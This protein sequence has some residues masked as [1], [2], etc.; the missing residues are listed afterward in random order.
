MENHIF[1]GR[2]IT[3]PSL[4]DFKPVKLWHRQLEKAPAPGDMPQD[5]HILFRDSFEYNGGKVYI[6]LTADDYFKLYINGNFVTQGPAPGFDFKYYYM[7]VDIT[8]HVRKGKNTVA[9]H[10]YYQGLV[11][12][13]WCSA[14]NRHGLIYDIF[15]DGVLKAKSSEKTKC[16]IHTAYHVIGKVGYDTQF[17]EMYDCR[18]AEIGFEQPEYDDSYWSDSAINEYADY[19]FIEQPTKPLDF[20]IIAPISVQKTDNGLMVDFGSQY[21]GY[22]IFNA[23]GKAG[24]TLKLLCGQELND[25]GNVRYKL[26]ANCTYEEEMVLSGRVDRFDQYDYMSF[27]YME[28]ILPEGCEISEIAFISRHYPFEAKRGCAYDDPKLKAVWELCVHSLKYGV[29]EVIQDC[30]EREKGQYLG[31]GSYTSTALA[32]LTD[33]TSMMEKMITNALDT[34]FIT[35]T[36]M[37]CSPCSFMQEIAEYVLMLPELLLAQIHI[38]GNT[39]FAAENF[40]R[41][42]AVLDAYRTEYEREDHLLYDL[43]KWCVVD[44]PQEARDSYDFD[45]TEGKVAVG[46]HNVINAYYIGAINSLNKIAKKLGRPIYRDT[47]ELVKAYRATFFC[48]EKNL[49]RDSPESGHCALP[50]NA[51][52]LAMGLCPNDETMNNIVDMIMSK[53]ATSSAFFMTFASMTGLKRLG[54][55]DLICEMIKNDS[56]WLNMIAEGHTTTI[57][58]WGKASKWNTSLFHLCY[59]FAVIFLSDWGME[60]LFI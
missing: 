18:S 49:F 33:D 4:K 40:D 13:V 16:T 6:Y 8:D 15:E 1:D 25:D 27:R 20:E 30:M 2:L 53:P 26:R 9:F 42:A 47:D 7:K 22:P 58:A 12:R 35:P 10:T 50:S 24:E 57:E 44:W 14:D 43:D 45:L 31:D 5:Q 46:T 59:A 54:R 19:K 3:H 37:T 55:N 56:R 34:A 32:I 36:L 52:A 11:N 38:S 48:P 29:Q 28:L 17:M 23:V 51:M 41:V 39:D 60:E 21:V